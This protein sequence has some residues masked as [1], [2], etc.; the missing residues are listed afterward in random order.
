VFRAFF[1]MLP[2]LYSPSI[3]VIR[4]MAPPIDPTE[5]LF[6]FGVFELDV[7]TAQL[8]RNGRKVRLQDQPIRVLLHLL[9]HRGELVTREQLQRALWP[10]D[11]FVDFDHGLNTAISKIRDALSDSASS[12]R[13]IET[14]PRRGYR[15]IA[16]VE[17]TAGVPTPTLP[18]GKSEHRLWFAA[19]V[20]VLITGVGAWSLRPT[21]PKAANWKITPFTT[22]ADFEREPSFSPDGERIAFAWTGPH[23]GAGHIYV[24]QV[25]SESAVQLT[26]G[27]ARDFM[28]AWSPDGRWIAFGRHHGGKRYSLHYVPAIGGQERAIAEFQRRD[29]G[30]IAGAIAWLP[31]S[32]AVI[33]SAIADPQKDTVALYLFF[34]QTGE[35]RRL[36]TSPS[37]ATGDIDPAMSPSGGSLA[38]V[39]LTEQSAALYLLPLSQGGHPAGAPRNVYSSPLAIR[40]PVWTPDG[41]DLIF[42]R[43]SLHLPQLWRLRLGEAQPHRLP[44]VA[45]RAAMP[46][47][48]PKGDRLAYTQFISN[49]SIASYR[50]SGNAGLPPVVW[51]GSSSYLDHAPRFSPDGARVAFKTDRSGTEN[52]WIA[53]ADGSLARPISN[54]QLSGPPVWLPDNRSLLTLDQSDIV[55]ID[56]QTG[57]I[58]RRIR[59]PGHSPRSPFLSTDNGLIYFSSTKTG[60]REIWKVPAA[61]GEA[62]QVTRGGGAAPRESADA[63]YLYFTKGHDSGSLWRM[64]LAGGRE[65]GQEKMILPHL[66]SV[67]NYALTPEGIYFIPPSDASQRS[68]IRFLRFA[69][70]RDEQITPLTKQVHWGFTLSPDRKT[71]LFT[72][73]E[74]RTSDLMLVENFR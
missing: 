28:P 67:D 29:I 45:D 46:A 52:L 9:E 55:F 15:F 66:S 70:G 12:P 14:I 5:K 27:E 65:K 54:Q 1:P 4:K 21:T 41:R 22:F 51:P 68:S 48:A 7:P 63:K 8:T 57:M 26:F 20:L 23:G 62:S 2:V 3:K 33:A 47:V 31:G 49:I 71:I 74:Q 17:P 10:E 34:L 19:G 42:E 30:Y 39:R 35:R 40:K 32:D 38:F 60:R 61:G 72:Q 13:F 16:P 64:P 18:S 43:G 24:K 44:F 36:T 73:S 69:T 37:D 53:N 59:L 50:L 25:G 6:R 56:V 58:Y 11:T